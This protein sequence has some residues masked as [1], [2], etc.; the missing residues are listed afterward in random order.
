[1]WRNLGVEDVPGRPALD[2]GQLSTAFF[3]GD[4]AVP[5]RNCSLENQKKTVIRVK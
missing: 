3:P 4:S 1:M 5:Q 2:R